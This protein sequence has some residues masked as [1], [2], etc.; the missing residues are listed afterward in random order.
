MDQM[1]TLALD[2]DDIPDLDMN[3]LHLA[4]YK[5]MC[6]QR[7]HSQTR[8]LHTANFKLRN[9]LD[10]STSAPNGIVDDQEMGESESSTDD[11]DALVTTVSTNFW[12]D[13][14]FSQ[15]NCKCIDLAL[16]RR[17]RSSASARL[18]AMK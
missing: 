5:S 13:I 16:D 14:V 2:A 7:F 12:Y 6:H 3:D 18:K 9:V 15:T 1:D 4:C 17:R 11:E 10:A 8:W